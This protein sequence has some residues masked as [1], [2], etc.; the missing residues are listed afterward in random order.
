MQIINVAALSALILSG[1]AASQTTFMVNTPGALFECQPGL[2][3]WTGGTA[4]YFPRI[5][6]AGST[7]S[8]L[9]SLPET[10]STSYTWTVNLAA[11][12]TFTVAV[13]DSTGAQMYSGIAPAIGAGSSSW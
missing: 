10:S 9:E 2:L 5:N 7:T 8:T 13:T 1:L 12:T 11:G 6:T 3:S 4:P